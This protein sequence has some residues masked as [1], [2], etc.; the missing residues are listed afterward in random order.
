ML[1]ATFV[2][3]CSTT[4]AILKCLLMQL[5]NATQTRSWALVI[6]TITGMNL[7]LIV[8]VISS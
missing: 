8:L 3:G 6:Y 5:G 1:L 2:S 4:T 7:H